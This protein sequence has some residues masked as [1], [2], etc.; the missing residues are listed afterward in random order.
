[1]GFTNTAVI[2]QSLHGIA[3]P[4]DRTK[5]IEHARRNQADQDV[6]DVLQRMPDTR[7]TSMADVFKGVGEAKE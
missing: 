1:M 5:L 7:Y 2:A 4:A 3:F 6:V